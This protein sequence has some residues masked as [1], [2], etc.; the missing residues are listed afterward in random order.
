MK[1]FL[2]SLVAFSILTGCSCAKEEEMKASDRVD[3]YFSKYQELDQELLEDLNNVIETDDT[4]SYEQK[5]QYREIMKKHYK[6]LEYDIKDEV[7]NG[8]SATVT[9]VIKVTDFSKILSESKAYLEEHEDEFKNDEGAYD[10]S[11]Y[12]DYRLNKLK[13]AKDKVEYTIDLTL[14][15]VDG[16]WYMDDIDSVTENKINGNYQTA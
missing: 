3:E 13:E 8:D 1:K 9:V 14:S 12:N 15:K 5:E 16:K 2:I 4:L 6:D 11:L 10:V 7:V